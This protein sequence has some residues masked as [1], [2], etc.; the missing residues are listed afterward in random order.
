MR[1][2]FWILIIIMI[3]ATG[4]S[5]WFLHRAKVRA[6]NSGNVHARDQS[7]SRTGLQTAG[8]QTAGKQTSGTQTSGT[9]A[10]GTVI[11]GQTARPGQTG[12][13]KPAQAAVPVEDGL[14]P[15]PASDSIRRNPPDGRVFAGS[16]K[17]QIYRQ[18]DIT[19]RLNTETGAACVLFATEAEWRKTQ[20]YRHGCGAA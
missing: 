17:Y 9:E 13:D 15:P 7:G 2:I 3:V 16:G 19:W 8:T 1:R 20:V 11:P 14:A 12:A 5:A 10:T 18:G 4:G 6:L